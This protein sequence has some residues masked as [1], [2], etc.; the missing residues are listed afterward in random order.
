MENIN[1]DLLPVDGERV[2]EEISKGNMAIVRAKTEFLYIVELNNQIHMF[3]HTVGAPGGGQKQFEKDEKGT[4][5][6]RKVV[7]LAEACYVC[8]FDK[9]Y[10]I[11]S[12][13]ATA[14][15]AILEMFPGDDRSNDGIVDFSVP[16]EE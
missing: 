2:F 14:E 5:I 6:V 13:M 9:G 7:D 16:E 8:E 12:V 11:Y 4:A 15:Q 3:S 10:N 1:L